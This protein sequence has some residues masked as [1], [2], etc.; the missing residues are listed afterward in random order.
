MPVGPWGRVYQQPHLQGAALPRHCAN[1]FLHMHRRRW[2]CC[3]HGCLSPQT[4]LSVSHS[5]GTVSHS[6]SCALAT[7]DAWRTPGAARRMPRWCAACWRR[8]TG[9]RRASPGAG[10]PCPSRTPCR[11]P[12]PRPRSAAPR[13]TRLS[14]G[15]G[16]RCILC[17]TVQCGAHTQRIDLLRHPERT[18]PSQPRLAGD[19]RWLCSCA[20]TQC[21]QACLEV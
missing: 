1:R 8:C 5:S 18:H 3:G 20:G 14:T 15:E 11:R 7:L 17:H 10:T 9:R 19:A 13:H 12:P 2:R 16:S 4:Q 6:T 21:M